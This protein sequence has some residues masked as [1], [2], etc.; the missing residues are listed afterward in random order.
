MYTNL[1]EAVERKGNESKHW[2]MM[3]QSFCFGQNQG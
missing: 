2:G 1:D 3:A